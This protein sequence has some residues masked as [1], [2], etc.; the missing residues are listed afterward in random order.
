MTQAMRV[1]L[2]G[3]L[4][5]GAGGAAT[6]DVEASTIHGLLT[7]LVERYPEMQDHID[8]GIAVSINGDIYRDDW[9][10]PIPAHADVFLIPRIKGG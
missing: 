6:I 9:T 3:T 1:S 7:A 5:S 2:T 10:Q 4:R 8:E